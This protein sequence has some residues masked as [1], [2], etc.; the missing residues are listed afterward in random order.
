MPSFEGVKQA[1]TFDSLL[2]AAAV[3]LLA[4]GVIKAIVS[5]VEAWKKISLRDRVKKL[6]EEVVKINH[7]LEI[8]NKRFKA[9]G[10]DMGQILQTLNALQVHF[11]TGN[12]HEKLRQS[13][14]ELVAYMNKRAQR[15]AEEV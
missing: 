13:N 3:I 14:D 1:L 8:G 7:R 12:D 11:I 2:I 9:Q 10:E 4:F 5:G 15:D 6:E